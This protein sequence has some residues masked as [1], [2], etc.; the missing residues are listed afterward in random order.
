MPPAGPNAAPTFTSAQTATIVENS[1]AAYQAAASDPEGNALTFSI[2]GGADSALFSMTPAGAL[3]FNSAPD[4]DLAGDADGNNIYAVQIRVSDGTNAVDQPVNITVGNSREGIAVR[5]VGT[6]FSRPLYVLAIPG[7]TDVY[8]LEQGGGVYRL[9]PA[10]GVRTLQFTVPNLSTGGEGGLL[11]M[12]L[13]PNPANSDRFLV[14][15]TNAAGDIEIRQYRFA[16]AGLPPTLLATF[17]IPHPVFD[18]H[19]G[20][21][22]A[23]GPD[24]FLYAATGDGGGGGDPN[25]NAQNP[26]VRL[27]K[28]LRIDVLP[29]PFAGASPVYFQPAAGNPFIAGGGDP[30]VFALG[31]RNPFRASFFGSRLI[32]GDVGQG[33]I[34][35]ID[36]VGTNQPGR[37]FGWRFLEGTRPYSGS[38]PAGL[39]AP[40]T[41][42]GHGTGP[43]QGRSVTGGYVYRGPI[44]SLR[45]R[46]VFGDFISG[47]IW[48]VPFAG[49]VDGQTLASSR[50][51]HRNEDFA[52]NSGTINSVASFGEDSAGNIF[53]VDYDGEIFMIVPA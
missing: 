39:T 41:E 19:N 45:D 16:A 32:I 24:G 22:M 2:T 5:R 21:W 47:N 30:Y 44:A 25:N 34:E 49:L 36:M 27:G 23:F 52:P 38:A 43:R 8:V 14:Y 46:Y 37:N 29:D 48:T 35:E 53:I 17:A 42:Y 13:L 3:S 28:I 33:A 1:T 20:G 15:C 51:E 26:N 7:S 9:N 40:V 4:Y 50:F 31:F 6:G 18:N 11:G 12:A 10:T